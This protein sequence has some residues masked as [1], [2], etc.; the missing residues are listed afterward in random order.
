MSTT[1]LP[2]GQWPPLL[3]HTP[4]ASLNEQGLPLRLQDLN[5]H[6]TATPSEETLLCLCRRTLSSILACGCMLQCDDNPGVNALHVEGRGW[7]L[8]GDEK[9]AIEY[10]GLYA[11]IRYWPGVV[12]NV[13]STPSKALG[14]SFLLALVFS[15]CVLSPSSY[16][17][18]LR[19]Y[20]LPYVQVTRAVLHPQGRS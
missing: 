2:L 8:S 18:V 1:L 19:V 10:R 13:P 14:I 3:R 9:N 7:V 16:I 15:I 5:L 20:P 17:S 6:V 11:N 12:Y 4:A